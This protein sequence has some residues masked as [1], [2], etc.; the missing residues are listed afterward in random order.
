MLY[1]RDAAYFGTPTNLTIVNNGSEL[2]TATLNQAI[3]SYAEAHD[4][5]I[6]KR[7]YPEFD[8]K[9]VPKSYLL[10]HPKQHM[11]GLPT[12]HIE[13]R[14]HI[15]DRDVLSDY[16]VFGT[17]NRQAFLAFLSK[18]NIQFMV[19]NPT[20]VPAVV[21]DLLG[22]LA[23]SRLDVLLVMFFLVIVILNS[24]I[25]FKQ[26][27]QFVMQQLLKGQTKGTALLTILWSNVKAYVVAYL[28]TMPIVAST[29]WLLLPEMIRYE[30][31]MM[32]VILLP[33]FGAVV[34]STTIL[35]LLF[36][37]GKLVAVLKG[38]GRQVLVPMVAC[39]ILALTFIN[40][41]TTLAMAQHE[42][43][44][45]TFMRQGQ[46][47]WEKIAHF[48]VLTLHTMSKQDDVQTKTSQSLLNQ[49]DESQLLMSM[50]A[51]YQGPKITMGRQ[52]QYARD[53]YVNPTYFN[54]QKIRSVTGKQFT[55]DD[56]RAPV[57]LLTTEN[58][59]PA[60]IQQNYASP[61]GINV[62]DIVVK[63]MQPTST[64]VF[65]NTTQEQSFANQKPKHILVI[66]FH[67]VQ[68]A[69]LTQADSTMATTQEHANSLI[70]Q[71]LL[72]W[73]SQRNV[74]VNFASEKN[75]NQVVSVLG[76]SIQD[77]SSTNQLRSSLKQTYLLRQNILL[78]S[79]ILAVLVVLLCGLFTI[80]IIFMAYRRELFV[81]QVYG[82]SFIHR[83]RQ[84]YVM[85]SCALLPGI[86]YAT[87][88]PDILITVML[89][90]SCL[91]LFFTYRIMVNEKQSYLILKGEL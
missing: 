77:V 34:I 3:T 25:I 20:A 23:V 60:Q 39:L 11:V 83:Y 58:L 30:L 37:R 24:F 9:I 6:V 67:A 5:V 54:E 62:A 1:A 26:R 38:R 22:Q 84:I 50:F 81:K 66:N 47:K 85:L 42:N 55:A 8:G 46:Q 80:Y 7:V 13:K 52:Q 51:P 56:F 35:T 71:N 82:I 36:N 73:L 28:M 49:L 65:L 88:K 63:K 18:N 57:T 32:N 40:F 27:R 75:K 16:G 79:L 78:G 70:V 17:G 91:L 86:F 10:G 59:S 68:H 19:Y 4:L 69:S 45:I 48:S 14:Q 21:S 43:R 33:F 76:P 72:S 31:I 12:H 87:S 53:L 41:V 90:I 64:Y 74:M 2:R 15:A 29:L 61:N 89:I 44:Q